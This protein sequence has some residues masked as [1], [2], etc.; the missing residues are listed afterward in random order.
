MRNA[1]LAGAA[2]RSDSSRDS[3]AGRLAGAISSV[4]SYSALSANPAFRK[5]R[6]LETRQSPLSPPQ[7]EFM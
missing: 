1:G 4:R 6:D 3:G 5:L 7:G 2:E